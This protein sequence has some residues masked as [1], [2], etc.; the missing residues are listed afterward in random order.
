MF[1]KKGG[2]SYL[3]QFFHK[4]RFEMAVCTL[5]GT[6]VG[7]GVLGMPYV[8][9]KAGFLYGSLLIFLV[10]LAFIT[11]N[12]YVGE[13]VLR[14]KD[15][16]Q[17]TGYME[18]YLGRHGKWMMTFVMMFG[19]YGAM[20][21]YIIGEGETIKAIIGEPTFL[22]ELFQWLP[23]ILLSFLFTHFYSLLF[24][25]IVALII[26]RGVKAA[27]PAELI[28]I[29]LLF[30]VVFIIGIYSFGNINVN[31]FSTFHPEFFFLPYG[32]I[33]FSFI[34]AAAIPEL[35]EELGKS[36]RKYMKKALIWGSVIPLI[37]YFFFT[38]IIVGLV[39]LE[40]F[41]L[42]SANQR[43]AT[44]AL[45]VYA[46]PV[47]GLCANIFAMFTMFTTFLTL[48]I[49]LKE[50]YH[51]DYHLNE[52]WAFVL[53]LSLPLILALSNFTSFIT[54]LAITGAVAGGLE[55]IL[56]VLAYWK[57]KKFGDRKPEYSLKSPKFVGYILLVLFSVGIL[58]QIW[59]NFF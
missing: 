34:G 52:K 36:G 35:Q 37:L 6:V 38:V 40:N 39:G 51:Y 10:G 25:F 21:A 19:I 8:I 42:L 20:T 44:V 24:F 13:I 5:V 57:A 31:Y 14:T 55:G 48:G 27:G 46:N 50:V 43:I 17:L 11:L 33:L 23:D 9:A 29:S 1:K 54:V 4:H 12:L 22:L 45:S 3:E 26:Y 47:L 2:K 28:I 56:V 53:T 32:V 58:Y 41:E 15:Q 49:A 18:K 16:R 7:A 59:Q 30:V